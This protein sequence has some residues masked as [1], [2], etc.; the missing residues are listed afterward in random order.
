M[1]D[2]SS[3]GKLLN[4]CGNAHAHVRR[5]SEPPK[6][7]NAARAVHGMASTADRSLHLPSRAPALLLATLATKADPTA[8]KCSSHS[9]Y[10]APHR[11]HIDA[12]AADHGRWWPPATF[13][14]S[15]A[16]LYSMLLTFPLLRSPSPV[17]RSPASTLF[18]V[19][20]VAKSSPPA[21]SFKRGRAA[22]PPCLRWHRG[23]K[24]TA[25]TP[26]APTGSDGRSRT[27]R[28]EVSGL[29]GRAHALESWH[30]LRVFL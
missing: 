13:T 11:A 2:T 15:P 25:D 1:Y 29:R 16:T 27:A 19:F 26:W 21:S 22:D 4:T 18:L 12:G 20:M 30:S 3:P 24:T 17:N 23:Y 28:S 6:V 10:H 14:T 8:S 5:P 9:L 7:H